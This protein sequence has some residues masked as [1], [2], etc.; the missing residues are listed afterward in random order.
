MGPDMDMVLLALLVVPLVCAALGSAYY[1]RLVTLSRRCDQAFA[2]IDVQLKHRHDLIPGLVETVKGFASHEKHII[3]TVMAARATAM[4]ATTADARLA[5]EGELSARL[6][7]MISV[8]ENNPEVRGSQHFTELRR[9][10]SDTENKIAAARRFLNMSVAEYNA[11]LEQFPANVIGSKFGL[12]SRR[13]YDLGAERVF[14][15]DAPAVK[16]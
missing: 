3:E 8:T 15:E 5:A 2:D 10:L 1:N 4:R 6:V 13:F 12:K 14:F 7:Q 9:D 16:F 11:S